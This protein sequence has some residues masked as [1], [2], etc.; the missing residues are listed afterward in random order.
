MVGAE[1]MALSRFLDIQHFGEP[2]DDI[3]ISDHL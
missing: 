3:E 2:I 1:R